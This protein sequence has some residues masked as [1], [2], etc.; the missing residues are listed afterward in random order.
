MTL[1]D[2]IA[3]QAHA[4][5]LTVRTSKCVNEY[6]DTWGLSVAASDCPDAQRLGFI[7]F[8]DGYTI[9]LNGDIQDEH[10]TEEEVETAFDVFYSE[11][12]GN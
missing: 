6:D 7:H 10:A 11:F 9:L 1:L 4:F 2:Q 8:T 5:G 12:L 3:A